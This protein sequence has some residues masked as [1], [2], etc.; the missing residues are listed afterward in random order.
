M[1]ILKKGPKSQRKNYKI[2]KSFRERVPENMYCADCGAKD[3]KYASVNLGVFICG[4]CR[5][6]HELLGQRVSIVKSIEKDVWT[7]EEMQVII[8]IIIIFNY[9]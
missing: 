5:H 9:Y 6:L 7:A 1:G 8:I 3:P 4:N 2:L